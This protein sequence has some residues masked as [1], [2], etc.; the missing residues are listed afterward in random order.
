VERQLNKEAKRFEDLRKVTQVR[1]VETLVK[2][3]G[4]LNQGKEGLD[5]IS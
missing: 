2:H 1:G 4:F 5:T 3:K